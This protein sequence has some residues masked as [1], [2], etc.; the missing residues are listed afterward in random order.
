MKQEPAQTEEKPTPV[1]VATVPLAPKVEP[2]K[3]ENSGF[4]GFF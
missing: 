3:E 1:P 2:E 4:L